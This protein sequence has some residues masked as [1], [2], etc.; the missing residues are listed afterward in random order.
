ML[1]AAVSV[2]DNKWKQPTW[3]KS[4]VFMHGVLYSN[5]NEQL[6]HKT[7]FEDSHKRTIA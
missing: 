1:A 2:I 7:T 5:S 6:Q 4:R 3:I